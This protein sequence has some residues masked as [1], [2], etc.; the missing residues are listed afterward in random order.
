MGIQ[1]EFIHA[2]GFYHEQSRPDRDQH[3]K[4]NWKNIQDEEYGQFIRQKTSLTFDVP[5]DGRSVMHYTPTAFNKARGLNS[6]E[7][8]IANVATSELGGKV[9]TENDIL[10]LK[11][12]Y[13]CEGKGNTVSCGRHTA[14]SCQG[15]P[16]GMEEVG[17]MEIVLGM[18]DKMCV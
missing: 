18:P 15:C 3:V 5:Y 2:L 17:A 10:K 7:S 14:T 11:R 4:I 16:Q 9:M 12:M 6:I 8:K 1:H 13:R